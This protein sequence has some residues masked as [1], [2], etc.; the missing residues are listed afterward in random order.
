MD[1]HSIQFLLLVALVLGAQLLLAWLL[2][3]LA[4][5]AGVRP[6]QTLLVLVAS[7]I[8]LAQLGRRIV[9]EQLPICTDNLVAYLHCLGL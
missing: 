3:R 8:L 5:R 7:G 6:W 9:P 2:L 1:N 4:R